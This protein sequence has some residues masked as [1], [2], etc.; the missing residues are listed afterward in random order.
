MLI[1]KR[2]VN[3]GDYYTNMAVDL[4]FGKL[5]ITLLYVVFHAVNI[6]DLVE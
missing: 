6:L 1:A 4:S 2:T 5:E 3:V